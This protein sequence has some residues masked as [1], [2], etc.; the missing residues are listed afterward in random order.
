MKKYRLELNYVRVILCVLIVITHL[1]TEYTNAHSNNQAQLETLYWIRMLLIFG[2][3]GFLMLT[4]LIFTLNLHGLPDNYLRRRLQYVFIPYIVMG[5]F[6]SYSES[7][8]LRKPFITQFVENVLKGQWYGYFILI[9]LK[10]FILNVLITKLWPKLLSS[11]IA[12]VI[13]ILINIVYLY[14]YHH[15]AVVGDWIDNTYFFEANTVILG[16]IGYY[17]VGSY[18]GSHYERLKAYFED[19]GLFFIG[20]TLLAFILFVMTGDHNFTDVTSNNEYIMLYCI[21]AF[22]CII[23]FSIKVQGMLLEAVMLISTYSFFIYLFHPIIL[24]YVYAYTERFE[25][26]TLLFMLFSVL[27]TFGACIGVGSLL[28]TFNIFKYVMGT[29]PY[30]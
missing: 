21:S 26:S 1:L 3:P 14:V 10:F 30:R 25:G 7:M 6:Y 24:Q 15:N 22:C 17:F 16:W 23:H 12:V 13:A 9:I 29:Q 2:T 19:Y 18:I 5:A 8:Y 27:L 20:I 11:R 28:R 4:Q